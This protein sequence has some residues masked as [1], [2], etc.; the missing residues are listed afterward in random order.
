MDSGQLLGT[1]EDVSPDDPVFIL[2]R[3]TSYRN[4]TSRKRMSAPLDELA[5]RNLHRESVSSASSTD[6]GAQNISLNVIA[7]AQGTEQRS[8]KEI[9]A[10]QRE[11]FRANQRAILSTQT[12]SVRGVDVLLPGNARLR[13]SRYEHDNRMRYS[14]VEP[15]GETYDISEI[16]EEEFKAGGGDDI[17]QGVGARI[18][19]KDPGVNEKLDRVLDRVK[20]GRPLQQQQRVETP[21]TA[22]ST[23][24][25]RKSLSSSSAYSADGTVEAGGYGSRS[26]T[27]LVSQNVARSSPTVAERAISPSSRSRS[28]TPGSAGVGMVARMISPTERVA[29]PSSTIGRSSPA[30]DELSSSIMRPG[31]TTPIGSAGIRPPSARRN[32]SVASA[33]SDVSGYMTA[34]SHMTSP[35]STGHSEATTP[36]PKISPKQ[37]NIPSGK[38]DFGVSQ[39]MAVIEYRAMA[40][41]PKVGIAERSDPVEEM[42]FGKKLDLNTLH[43]KIRDLY[44]ASFK[45]MEEMDLVCDFWFWFREIFADVCSSFWINICSRRTRRLRLLAHSHSFTYLIYPY[46]LVHLYLCISGIISLSSNKYTTTCKVLCSDLEPKIWFFLPSIK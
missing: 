23:G 3:A 5:L 11:A 41:K 22:S 38:G 29:S 44:A 42:L 10:A 14:Y 37:L 1:L 2:R 35:S 40:S 43:P 27:P 24:S 9:I 26:T 31:T 19:K 34:A 21:L 30:L 6:Q 15:D 46:T 12:N 7:P 4:T 45:E 39:M 13:S 20:S 32:P 16:V 8:R 33:A 28:N 25:H 18:G 17:F 36:V